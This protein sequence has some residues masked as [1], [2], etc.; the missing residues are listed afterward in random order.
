M[1]SQNGG[2]YPHDENAPTRGT[3]YADTM[4]KVA[5]SLKQTAEALKEMGDHM[6]ETDYQMRKAQYERDAHQAEVAELREKIDDVIAGVYHDH[7]V[8]V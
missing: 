3:R 2:R 6:D 8:G 1:V 4:G 7:E 5:E